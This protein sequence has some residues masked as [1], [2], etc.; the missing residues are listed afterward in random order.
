MGTQVYVGTYAKYNDGS[1]EGAWID[2]E[3]HNDEESFLKACLELHKDEEDPELM[4]QDFEGFPK[5][6]YH[7]SSVDDRLW[8]YL[9]LSEDERDTVDI[10]LENIDSSADIKT[11]LESYQGTHDSPSD[12]ASELLDSTGDLETIPAHLRSYFDFESYARDL[13]LG[14][15]YSFVRVGGQTYVFSNY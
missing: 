8:E 15:D 12:F 5:A 4:F 11:A 14:D 3:T 1:I 2:L 9:Q 13:E 10:Y 6:F 7:E